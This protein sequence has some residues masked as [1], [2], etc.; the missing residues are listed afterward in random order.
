[1]YHSGKK[2]VVHF[3]SLEDRI[4]FAAGG[5]PNEHAAKGLANAA[6]HANAN[7]FA[8]SPVF[9]QFVP[10]VTSVVITPDNAANVNVLT[11]NPTAD[12]DGP[13]TFTYQWLQNGEPVAGA[14]AQTLNLTTQVGDVN[15]GDTFSVVVTAIANSIPSD[16]FTSSAVTIA[17]A[18]PDP[19]TLVP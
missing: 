19:I 7:A 14:T 11:A 18:D 3:E 17:T 2:S 15:V 5:I 13:V 4:A 10:V 12:A 6:R 1:M 16:P 8:H 9:Q